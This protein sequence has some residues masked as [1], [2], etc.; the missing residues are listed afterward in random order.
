M[1][2]YRGRP[3]YSLLKTLSTGAAFIVICAIFSGLMTGALFTI[4]EYEIGC[5]DIRATA[6]EYRIQNMLT[7]SEL[8]RLE[9]LI[10]R[11][12]STN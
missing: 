6:E 3:S 10:G 9:K 8:E 7:M 5:A 12:G 2:Y 1:D 11:W 4:A